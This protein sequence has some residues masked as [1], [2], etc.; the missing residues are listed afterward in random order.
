[1]ESQDRNE[2]LLYQRFCDFKQEWIPSPE[3]SVCTFFVQIVSSL[4]TPHYSE[5]QGTK[6]L[7]EHMTL[8]NKTG[9]FNVK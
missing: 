5:Y 3:C 6:Q 4:Q 2:D 9:T 8:P 7:A 1:M